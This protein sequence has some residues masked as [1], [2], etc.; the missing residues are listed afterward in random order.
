MATTLGFKNIIDKAEWR[1]VGLAA[2]TQAAGGSLTGDLRTTAA[3]VPMVYCLRSATAFDVYNPISDDWLTLASPGLSGTFG[4]GAGAVQMPSHGPKGV[5]AGGNTT[6]TVVIST[7]LAAAVGVNSLANKGDSAGYVIRIIGNSAGGSG[8]VEERFITANTAGTA[9][10]ITLDSALT[11]TPQTGDG[12][13]ILAGRVYLM[14]AGVSAAGCWKFYDIAT[15]SFSGNLA[16]TNLP[17][18]LNTDSS[19][20]G[21]DEGHV[22]YDV[23]AATGFLGTLT[24]TASSSTTITGQAAAGD[25]TVLA[26]EY[27]N[28]QIRIVEDTGTPTAAGQRRNIT[29]HTAGGSPVYTVP[30]WTVTPS[31]TAKFVIENNGD[32]ILYWGSGQTATYTYN[33]TAN[34]WDTSTFG[35]RSAAHVAGSVAGHACTIRPDGPKNARHSHVYVLRSGAIIDLFDIAGGT[36]GL[37][38]ANIPYGNGAHTMTIVGAGTCVEADPYTDQGR[39]FL[40]NS[41]A[42]NRFVKFD[43]LNRVLLPGFQLRYAQGGALTGGRMARTQF[44]DGAVKIQFFYIWRATG[45]EVFELLVP[46]RS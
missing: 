34:T 14:S 32:R 13:E 1:P 27:R 10:T 42:S 41:A 19:F 40:V 25:A 23:D 37:W 2:G 3:R 33:S 7:A 39:Y 26:N 8:K 17:A 4:A 30:S 46:P 35:A 20:I 16:T 6:T 28:F 38:T 24:A 9:P 44:T 15:N 18:T 31:S 12:Y 43:M 21:L 29:S 36:N 11:F 5:L 22:P 45:Q